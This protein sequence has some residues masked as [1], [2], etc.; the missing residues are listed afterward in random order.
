LVAASATPAIALAGLTA[1]STLGIFDNLPNYLEIGDLAEKSEIYATGTDG[2]PVLLATFYAQNREDVSLSQISPFI[3]DAAI[4]S[5][6]P[7]FYEHG[8]VDLYGTVR[9]IL[10]NTLSGSTQGGSSITQQYVKNVLVQKAEAI[11]NPVARKKAYE[12]A[13]QVS[14]DRK[15]KEIKLSI[16][17]EQK[18]SKKQILEGYLNITPFGGRVYGVQ[19]AAKYYFGKSAKDVTVAE[20][21][22]LIAI[23]NNPSAYRPDLEENISDN[24]ARRDYILARMLENK[25]ITQKEYAAAVA[26]PVTLTLTEASTGCQTAP[27]GAAYFCDYITWVIKNDEAFGKTEDERWTAFQRGGWKIYSTLSLPLQQAASGA[28]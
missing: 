18:Y 7:R 25:K 22:S 24:Q 2:K 13:T 5:E 26:S 3:Q 16:G 27:F 15:L 14:V 23:I 17:V 11:A 6:D 1:N 19:A 20:A 9:A 10:S 12:E 8:G 4:A 21:A 28:V